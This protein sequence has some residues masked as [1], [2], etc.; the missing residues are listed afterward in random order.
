MQAFH[1]PLAR[2]QLSEFC[3]MLSW[4]GLIL[5]GK[6]SWPKMTWKWDLSLLENFVV[7]MQSATTK[8]EIIGIPMV[9]KRVEVNSL[10]SAHC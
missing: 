7:K 8:F 4:N 9:L 1:H 10:K 3:K 2:R 5:R 6:E